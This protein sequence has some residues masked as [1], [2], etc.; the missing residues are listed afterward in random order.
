MCSKCHGFYNSSLL[1]KHA[2]KCNAIVTGTSD[3]GIKLSAKI[4]ATS[5]ANFDA[6]LLSKF[7]TDEIGMLCR[8]DSI[9]TTVGRILWERSIR[10]DR[11]ST[12]GEMRKLGSLLQTAK[13]I[14][15]NANL[16]GNDILCTAKSCV[17]RH[18]VGCKE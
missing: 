8:T 2:L 15:N 4:T 9:I 7:R 12:M 11:K 5:N 14:S 6:D 10:K 18:V 16:T 13:S 1:W 3:D 17:L